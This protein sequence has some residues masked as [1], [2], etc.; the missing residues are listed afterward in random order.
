MKIMQM[1][2]QV[3][4]SDQIN[5]DDVQTLLGEGVELLVCNRPDGEDSDQTPYAMIQNEAE[6]LGLETDSIAFSSYRIQP[7]SRDAFIKL[8]RTR[9]RIHLYCRSGSRSERLWREA[10]AIV[11]GEIQYNKAH[12]SV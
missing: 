8:I 7:E 1:T 4:V 12:Q 11:G 6:K 9:K 5:V 2:S 10:N 3:S